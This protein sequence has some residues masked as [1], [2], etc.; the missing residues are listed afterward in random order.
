MFE[1]PKAGRNCYSLEE[2]WEAMSVNGA[3]LKWQD[4]IMAKSP[5]DQQVEEGRGQDTGI[6]GWDQGEA[7]KG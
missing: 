6:Q 4:V 3:F 7:S 5:E 2:D 1:T